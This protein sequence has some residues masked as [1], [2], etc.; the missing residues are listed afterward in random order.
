MNGIETIIE[1]VLLGGVYALFALGLSLMFG[2]MRLVNLAHGDLIVLAAYLMLA[3]TNALGLPLILAASLIIIVMFAVGFLL[4][5][6]VLERVLGDDI[7][8][9]LLVSFGL[10]IIIQNGLLLAYGAD[11]HRLQGGAFESA[12]IALGPDLNI[13]LAPLTALF[14]AIA[15][16]ALLELIFYRTSLGRAFRATADNPIVAQLM[17][18]DE[19]TVYAVA[20]G[21][22][23]SISVIAAV[24]FGIRANFDPSIGPAR[25]LY[26]FESVIIGGL[27]SLWGTLA[28][29]IVL[30]LAQAIGARIN[31][32]W[33]IL[34]G[35]LAFLAVLVMRPRGLF[36]SRRQ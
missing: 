7:L 25:L 1:G 31:P 32:E 36:P 26:A 4:Q 30:G 29:G 21:L 2:I 11:S 18:I 10:S 3:L 13:G 15:A 34:A 8:P 16:V 6:L 14:S 19:R 22:S 17:G 33:Q 28:G 9:P 20:V 35:H 27:G 12:S 23:L 5:R 24:T